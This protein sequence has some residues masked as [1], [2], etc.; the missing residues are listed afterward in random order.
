MIFTVE[1]LLAFGDHR[2]R[3]YRV[4]GKPWTTRFVDTGVAREDGWG[5]A[6]LPM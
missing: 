2:P 5:E 6:W 4:S 1:G 3:E